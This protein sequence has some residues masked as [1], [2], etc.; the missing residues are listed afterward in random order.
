[1]LS[2]AGVLGITIVTDPE[3]V[4]EPARLAVALTQMFDQLLQP[5]PLGTC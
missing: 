3:I 2:Y 4:D 1:M 5:V